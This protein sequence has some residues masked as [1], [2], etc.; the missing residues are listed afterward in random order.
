M[1]LN[2]LGIDWRPQEN[3]Q[4]AMFQEFVKYRKAHNTGRVPYSDKSFER[5]WLWCVQQRKRYRENTLSATE[6][7]LLTDA[8]FVWESKGGTIRARP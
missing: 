6:L 1:L 5:L 8:G 3:K 2:M 4:D 7:Q